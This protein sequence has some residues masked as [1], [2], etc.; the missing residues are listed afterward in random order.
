MT[1]SLLSGRSRKSLFRYFFVTL[2]FFGVSGSVGPFAPHYA[3]DFARESF[4]ATFPHKN[5]ELVSSRKIA[6]EEILRLQHEIP[7]EVGSALEAG[8]GFL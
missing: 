1:F 3:R 7:Q 2:F 8:P 4:V 5:E 6:I